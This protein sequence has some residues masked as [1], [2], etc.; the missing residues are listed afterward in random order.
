M[1]QTFQSQ[2]A[3]DLIMK[4]LITG[5]GGMLGRTLRRHFSK[6]EL[7]VADL[8]EVDI[9]NPVTVNH[10][11]TSTKPDLV[12]HCA[13]MTN[14]DECEKDP[15]QAYK[16][17][18]LGSGV[19]AMAAYRAQARLIAI[20]TDYV[21]DGA[22][23]QPYTEFDHA[24]PNTVYGAS[25]LAGEAAIRA[26]CPDHTIIRIAWLYGNSGPSFLHTMQK[27]GMEEGAPLK[28]VD[29]QIGNPTST[30]AVAD[31]IE[32]LIEQPI[33]G[34][35]HGSCEGT[36]TWFEFAKEIFKV[37]GLKREVVPCSTQEFPRPAPRPANS[38]LD[39]QV[40]RMAG[41]NPMP[42]WRDALAEYAGSSL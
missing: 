10:T 17:N 22:S 34:V 7:V 24:S 18:A 20:S 39:K 4:I 6:Y 12:I 35:I 13:A 25:K 14:V 28:V 15:E 40:L 5:G 11:M 32:Q 16:V 37:Y 36:A 41:M 19:V 1:K 21:F 38:R 31:L 29:D 30:N 23:E 3:S 26:H 2:F 42:R 27:L 33:P 8:P 9:T